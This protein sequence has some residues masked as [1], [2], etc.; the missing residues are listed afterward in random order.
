M[1]FEGIQEQRGWCLACTISFICVHDFFQFIF[2][3]YYIRN[4]HKCS[5]LYAVMVMWLKGAVLNSGF[6]S[7]FKLN[8]RSFNPRQWSI[9]NRGWM[10]L[11]WPQSAVPSHCMKWTI[12]HFLSLSFGIPLTSVHA[13][14][15]PPL[16][17]RRNGWPRRMHDGLPHRCGGRNVL[18]NCPLRTIELGKQGI[19]IFILV[20]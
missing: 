8:F 2:L 10:I 18:H 3:G 7:K 17:P 4:C 15:G 5:K 16:E 1:A 9:P 13:F 19:W 14:Y 11:Q 6:F 12:S 20:L